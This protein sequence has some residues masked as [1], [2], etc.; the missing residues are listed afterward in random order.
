MSVSHH[1]PWKISLTSASQVAIAV[2]V[3]DM[4]KM[5][6]LINVFF[7]LNDVSDGMAFICFLLF[8]ISDAASH[9]SFVSRLASEFTSRIIL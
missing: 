2:K 5:F 8:H 7:L 6:C 9:D 4:I 3:S 1:A